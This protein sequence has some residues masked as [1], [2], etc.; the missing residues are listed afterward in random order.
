MDEA[1]RYTHLKRAIK[2]YGILKNKV[3]IAELTEELITNPLFFKTK[4]CLDELTL[5][6]LIIE[7]YR[8]ARNFQRVVDVSEKLIENPSFNT[9]NVTFRVDVFLEAGNAYFELKDYSKAKERYEAALQFFV[10]KD[11]PAFRNSLE[12]LIRICSENIK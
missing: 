6:S 8:L 12:L 3:R 7:S 1:K 11:V 9:T 5:F 4:E 2:S 10:S